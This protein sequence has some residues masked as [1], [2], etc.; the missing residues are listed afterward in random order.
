MSTTTLTEP[1]STWEIAE[2]ENVPV[3]ADRRRSPASAA[4]IVLTL[5]AVRTA[6]REKEL[7]A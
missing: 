5:C 7:T 6:Q 4:A 2:F 1:E 3:P